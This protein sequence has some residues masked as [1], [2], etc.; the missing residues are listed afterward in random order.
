M[1]I[2][3][4]T[5]AGLSVLKRVEDFKGAKKFESILRLSHFHFTSA[6]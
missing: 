6:E 4:P 5:Y 2:Y 1:I 3:R